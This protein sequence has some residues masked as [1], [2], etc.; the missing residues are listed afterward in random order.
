MCVCKYQANQVEFDCDYCGNTDRK[1]KSWYNQGE[2]T[3][4]SREC[5]WSYF[6]GENSPRWNEDTDTLHYG[7][8]WEHAKDY[9]RQRDGGICQRCGTERDERAHQI[10]HIVK[11]RLFDEWSETYD[12]VSVEDSNVPR[13]LV[14][15]CSECHG[16]VENGDAESPVPERH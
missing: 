5:R 2:N 11:I 8:N 12:C 14:T 10:H 6:S 13:N 3:F 7:E 16:R 9:V 1:R 15:L 4:C